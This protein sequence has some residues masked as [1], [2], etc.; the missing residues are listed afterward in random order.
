VCRTEEECNRC[1]D[2]RPTG[3]ILDPY[4]RE[5]N[6]TY[7]TTADGQP[8]GRLGAGSESNVVNAGVVVPFPG[9]TPALQEHGGFELVAHIT[10]GARLEGTDQTGINHVKLLRIPGLFAHGL[11]MPRQQEDQPRI[12][13]QPA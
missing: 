12:L 5:H 9:T 11:L 1:H 3:E 2:P 8:G 13:Q 4:V 6:V 10:V 7:A